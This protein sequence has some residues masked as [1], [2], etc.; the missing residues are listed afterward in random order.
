MPQIPV[1]KLDSNF[2]ITLVLS[3]VGM[4]YMRIFALLGLYYW[5]QGVVKKHVVYDVGL[6]T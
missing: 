3:S 4:L 2:T 5:V 6:I 1:I